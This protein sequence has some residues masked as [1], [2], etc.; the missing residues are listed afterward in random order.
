MGTDAIDALA[1]TARTNL[2]ACAML[3]DPKYQPSL[4]HARLAASV[5]ACMC[6]RRNSR[7]IISVPPRHGKSR[8]TTIEAAS[9]LLGIR[10]QSEIITASYG[11]SLAIR[12]SKAV[13]WRIQ[14]NKV[15]NRLFPRTQIARGSA[16]A[17][18]FHT[19]E[20]GRYQAV[21]VGGSIG[22]GNADCLL[23]G[24]QIETPGG[25]FPI[26]V[27]AEKFAGAMVRSYDF[28]AMRPVWRPAKA[29]RV[30]P[31]NGFYRITTSLGSV[32]EAT[33][34]HPFWTGRG[35]VAAREITEGD[36]FMRIVREINDPGKR[37][38]HEALQAAP[39]AQRAIISA[40]QVGNLAPRQHGVRRLRQP[41]EIACP[42]HQPRSFEQSVLESG[43][44]LL[45]LPLQAAWGGSGETEADFVVL[46]E[47]VCEPAVVYNIQVEGTENFFAN[48]ILVHNCLILDDLLKDRMEGDS[49]TQRNHVW[50][51]FLSTA[52]TRLASNGVILVIGTRWHKDD[53]PGRLTDPARV[54]ELEE[55]GSGEEN[56]KLI[57]YKALAEGLDDPL[58]RAEGES[59]WP[60]RW[61]SK[62]MRA[63]RAVMSGPQGRY[64]WNALFRGEPTDRESNEE[65]MR[66]LRYIDA[67]DLPK[68]L[69]QCR[70]WDLAVTDKET[71][72]FNSGVRGGFHKATGLFYI[73]HVWKK[74]SRWHSTRQSINTLADLDGAGR[75]RMEA[76]GAFESLF[77][78]IREDRRGKDMV[79][80]FKPTKNKMTRATP[81]MAAV[82]AGKVVLVRGAW[83]RDFVEELCDFPTGKHDDQIDATSGL[84]EMTTQ[85]DT[86]LYA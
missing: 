38:S 5:Q 49:K 42:S 62:R 69:E 79:S 37:R 73:S 65:L 53:L 48:G 66:N 4:F 13:R 23:A 32:V 28:Q 34:E 50:E 57:N 43:D 10:P 55:A 77:E 72:D 21:G 59:L 51:W 18:E 52:Y 40:F 67:S 84:W 75:I 1:A 56:F 6:E 22:G 63:T 80:M 44:A 33:G 35:W 71:S 12:S 83:N 60:E 9:F 68:D 41:D 15:Y 58:G 47:H 81:W 11:L 46:V 31:A 61:S 14:E 3:C 85:Q 45:A 82:E 78:E 29:V 30:R 74:Q 2:L 39:A 25:F 7:L 17:E 36:R 76:I 20:G 86:L 27:I 16:K 54:Q 19:T 26:E 8:L 24:T 64:E 70:S